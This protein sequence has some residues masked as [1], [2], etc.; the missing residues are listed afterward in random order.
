M[1]T[2]SLLDN[3]RSEINSPMPAPGQGETAARHLRLMALGREDLELARLAEAHW[4]A[5]AI[6]G[7]ANREYESGAIYGVWASETPGEQLVLNPVGSSFVLSGTK[8]FCSGTGILTNALVIVSE[9]QHF[10][11]DIKLPPEGNG[12]CFDETDWKTDAFDSIHTA[13][14]TFNE[15]PIHKDQIVGPP[16]WYLDRVGF[17]WGACGPAACWAGGG[18]ALADYALR[19]LRQ[20]AHSLAHL[21]AMQAAVWEL[22]SCLIQA[23]HNIDGNE[24]NTTATARILALTLRH[25]VE[26]ACTDILRRFAR[27]Y[28]PRPLISDEKIS[29]LYHELDLYLRQSHAERDLEALGR[30]LQSDK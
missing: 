14:T 26:Q 22:R 13:K 18:Q 21:G 8:R 28:G 9:P 7:E 27:A 25:L 12:I 20:D 23:G 2:P 3:L 19:Q 29:R 10:L 24:D 30:D 17:W 1:T 5:I 11:L 15:L 4:D 6:L 16:R